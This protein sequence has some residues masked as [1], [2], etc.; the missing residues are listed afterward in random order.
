MKKI[1][2]DLKST[3]KLIIILIFFIYQNIIRCKYS[4]FVFIF[5]R[6]KKNFNKSNITIK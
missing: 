4:R 1:I 2:N 5:V 6:N 3:N